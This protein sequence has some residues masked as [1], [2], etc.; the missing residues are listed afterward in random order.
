MVDPLAGKRGDAFLSWMFPLH[1]GDAFGTPGRIFISLFGLTPL[2]FM[3]T[4]VAV[5]L[6]QRRSKRVVRNRMAAAAAAA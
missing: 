2:I 4:G 1:T 5:W 3:V 6:K